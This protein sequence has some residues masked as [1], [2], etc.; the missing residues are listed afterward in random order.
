MIFLMKFLHLKSFSIIIR[1]YVSSKFKYITSKLESVV[2]SV[3][4]TYIDVILFPVVICI[5]VLC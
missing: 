2:N 5:S 3:K 4:V 1:N